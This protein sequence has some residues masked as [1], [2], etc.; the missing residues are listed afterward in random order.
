[1]LRCWSA[2]PPCY[3]HD[4]CVGSITADPP[5]T[6]TTLPPPPS[7]ALSV[8]LPSVLAPL[9]SVPSSF[10]LHLP[11]FCAL[12]SLPPAL[13][14]PV[15][16]SSL[17]TPCLPFP[18][19]WCPLT[20]HPV[21]PPPADGVPKSSC[22]SLDCSPWKFFWWLITVASKP[23]TKSQHD[24]YCGAHNRTQAVMAISNRRGLAC[25]RRLAVFRRR[26]TQSGGHIFSR[27]VSPK[28]EH[29]AS[30]IL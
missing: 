23:H 11:V 16:P 14:V 9:H 20:P 21:R 27:S 4:A 12:T 30:K 7:P 2:L 28:P 8:T 15:Q 17:F 5:P 13:S 19:W 1:M 22:A 6:T 26:P 3:C 18:L 25:E 29:L 24:C 10:S